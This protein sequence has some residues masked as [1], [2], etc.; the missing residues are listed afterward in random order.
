MNEIRDITQIIFNSC[1]AALVIFVM[2]GILS[3]WREDRKR[4][5][6]KIVEEIIDEKKLKDKSLSDDEIF[7]G[8]DEE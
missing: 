4:E 3:S 7:S 1:G 5:L 8:Y 2:I 6:R